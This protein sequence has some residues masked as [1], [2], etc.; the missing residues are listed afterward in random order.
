[1]NATKLKQME[2]GK[3]DTFN[4]KG[5]VIVKSTEKEGKFTL[6]A[7]SAGLTSDSATWSRRCLVRKKIVTVAFAPCK[8]TTDVTTNL[9]YL[10]Q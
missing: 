5:V 3:D 4:G 1:M 10:K 6:Y 9:N 8:A 7:D 2:H